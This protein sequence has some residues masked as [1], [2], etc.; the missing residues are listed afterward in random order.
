MN[1]RVGFFVLE[2][3]VYFLLFSCLSSFLMHFVVSSSLRLKRESER[4][5]SITSLLTALDY[6]TNEIQRAPSDLR[7][8][9][10]QEPSMIVWHSNGN[11][12]DIG[13]ARTKDR[14]WRIEGSYS[15]FKDTWVQKKKSLLA[16]HIKEINFSYQH[17]TVQGKKQVSVVDCSLKGLLSSHDEYDVS[18]SVFLENRMLPL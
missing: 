18:K 11:N 5:I 9:K 3:L 7:L 15:T 4:V 16:T 13:I 12:N 6:V 10:K 17:Y 2:F 8:W 14:I 1:A